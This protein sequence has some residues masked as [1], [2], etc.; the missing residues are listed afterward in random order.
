MSVQDE[1]AL[2]AIYADTKTIAVVGA[3]ADP[4]KPSHSRPAYL[5]SQ[6]YTIIP[7]SPRGGELFGEPVLL[8]LDAVQGPVDV[9]DVFRPSDEVPGIAHAAAAIG[10]KVLWLQPGITS[11][12]GEQIA[13][14]AGITFVD[15][16]C[17]ATMH[18][19]LGFGPG[20]A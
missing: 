3:S 12:E 7:V 16:L 8:S 1:A 19:Q 2:R 9:V 15:G 20:P 17:M 18:G 14:D 10:A 11:D 6:G 13:S 5:Q 4:S